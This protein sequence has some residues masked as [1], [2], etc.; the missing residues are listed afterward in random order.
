MFAKHSR[1]KKQNIFTVNG[2][3]IQ[4]AVFQVEKRETEETVIW[5][6]K[7]VDDIVLSTQTLLNQTNVPLTCR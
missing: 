2:E 1:N 3:C 5:E 4:L 6:I 7:K